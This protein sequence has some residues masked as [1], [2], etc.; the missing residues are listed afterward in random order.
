[1]VRLIYS[2][3]TSELLAELA[4]RVRAQQSREGPLVPVR[5]AV[6]SPSVETYARLGIAR[7]CGV[8]ANL[9]TSL[10]TPWAQ[11]VCATSRRRVADAAAIE[12]MALALLLDDGFLSEPELGAVRS[13]LGAC[14]D[15]PD[16]IDVRRVQLAARIGRL[17]EEYTFS[18]GEMLTG[19][20]EGTVFE[21]RH[22][23]TERWQRRMW[24]AMFGERGLAE[25]RT[26]SDEPRLVPLPCEGF[27]EDVDVHD[28]APLHLWG[29]PGRD[30]VRALNA[31]AGFDHEDRFVD[32]LRIE[33]H[34]ARTL[35]RQLQ[36]DVLR[37]ETAQ[38]LSSGARFDR[39][40]S[41][42]VLEHASTRR[43][44]EAV[45]SEIWRLVESDASLHFDDIAI[46]VPEADAQTYA[47][48]LRAVF[49]EAHDLPYQTVSLPLT[50][51]S[52]VVEA[53]L[54][55]LQLP[56]GRFT[57]SDL[58]RVV[59]HP[60]VAGRAEEVNAERWAFWCDAL[61]IVHGADR[62]DHEGTYIAR[63]ILN[64]DQGLRRLALGSFMVGDASGDRTA[65]EVGGEAYVPHEVAVSEIHEAA[66]F[67]LLLRSIVADARFARDA[68]LTMGQWSEFL[69]QLVL[70]YVAPASRADEELLA[71][72]LRGIHG[73]GAID[74]GERCVR[75]RV[76]YELARQR[77][78]AV[79]GAQ[80]G[81]G[82]V[83]STL[84]ARER[85]R[86]AFLELLLSA[87]DR[88]IL[89]YVSRDPVTGDELAPSSLVRELLH[90]LAQGYAR[91]L[92]G[93]RRRHPL[94]R[95]D[96]QYFP[97]LFPGQG[98]GAGLGGA[99]RLP[100][101]RAEAQTLAL[102]RDLESHGARVT[103]AEVLSRSVD[104]PA[105]AI[106]SSHLGLTP[107]P[108][109]APSAETRVRVPLYAIVK[110]LDF[111]LQA[112]AR[113]RLGLDETDDEDA[114]ARED[115]SFETDPREE[116][117]FL[118]EVL[119]DSRGAAGLSLAQVY[120][121][122]AQGRA[123]R[124]SGPS[125]VFARGE[126][127]NHLETL[128]AWCSE[129]AESGVTVDSIDV[130]R[131]GRG[132]QLTRADHTHDALALDVDVVDSSGVTRVVCVEVSGGLLPLGAEGCIS[133]T[134]AKRAQQDG[135]WAGAGRERAA[136][137]AFVDHAVLSASG[138]SEDRPFASVSVVASG[139]ERV[140]DR[141]R[142]RALS[143]D[144]ATIWLRGIVRDL[145]SGP[146]AYFLPC[147][148]V[149]VHRKRDPNAA[150]TLAIEEARLEL[151]DSDGPL[152]LR[153]AYG[154]V[155]RPHKYPAPEESLAREMIT[156]R[157]KLFFDKREA[158]S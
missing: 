131:F 57:R 128:E 117:M 155:P 29:R 83:V 25:R 73:M 139:D 62:R 109:A 76:A 89:S 106:V 77:L 137:R 157:F 140:T 134:L 74:L 15:V 48:Q 32:P 41:I 79:I 81:A 55:L 50:S 4:S 107:L 27:W 145:L 30:Q 149:F 115:E 36:S 121:V 103:P 28:P 13:Y 100:E 82:V 141:V 85:D 102:R 86:Y 56:L 110:F 43:E 112:W 40:D 5:I 51:A 70:T 113:F 95:W 144:E 148:A 69:R 138:V 49:R 80:A 63:D 120:D 78:A 14:G 98:K 16:P 133:L 47:A 66:D 151:G 124:G 132:A 9:R 147:E 8:A 52:S 92:G 53:I 64:W 111:P 99:M 72:S 3:R 1:M 123:L 122:A 68:E 46:V 54:L 12:A 58:L 105:W 45:A 35:L 39:D 84:T 71:R 37:R 130:H 31:V 21:G 91:D 34:D 10:L 22:G 59:A 33:S 93:M 17:F 125:G 150:V 116:T 7:A 96:P 75:Y 127:E 135:E 118:R 153:S 24:L 19:W 152:A 61:G 119:L 146:H 142:F 60:A 114:A 154:P 38:A 20:R 87:E 104:D 44:L 156:R 26:A 42:A 136:L 129:L 101:A 65:F 94:L 6:P 88:L 143:R 108:T 126:R 90:A 67:G 158:P 23:E 11:E 18:R 2:N 97:D